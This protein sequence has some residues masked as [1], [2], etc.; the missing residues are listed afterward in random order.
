M[1]AG[2]P[3]VASDRGLEGLAVG[4]GPQPLRALR[5]NR[6]QEYVEAISS[7]F[8]NP[9]LRHELSRNARSHI[10]SE[11]TWDIAGGRYEQLLQF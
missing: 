11:Y 3:V 4:G 9:H 8:E 1:A 5:A 7:L 2:T 6:V 10:E